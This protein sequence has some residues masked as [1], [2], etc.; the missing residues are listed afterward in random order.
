MKSVDL[1]N[2]RYTVYEDGNVYSHKADLYLKGSKGKNG[3]IVYNLG[4]GD[5]KVTE[6][7]HR[8]VAKNFVPNPENKP[9]VN[10]INGDKQD[11]RAVNLEWAAY[12]EN[13]KHAF[14]FLNRKTPAGRYLG[15]GVC[16][17]KSKNKYMAYTDFNSKR[18]Y[19]GRYEDRELAE[20]AVREARDKLEY[21]SKN[22]ED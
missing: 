8:I 4:W 2:G 20:L 9:C 22:M 16:F 11:N 21:L 13:H 6:Y 10:H 5:D 7:G 3:Y 19:H 14:N 15:G 1:L 18:R 12:S 17:D